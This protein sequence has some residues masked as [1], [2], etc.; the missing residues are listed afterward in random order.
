[1]KIISECECIISSSLHGLIIADSFLI[2]NQMVHLT[3]KLYG[4]GFKFDDYYSN[5]DINP[6]IFDLNK[7]NLIKKS[8]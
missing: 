7:S 5:F 3:D 6:Q 4:D 8:Q 2:P 1:M